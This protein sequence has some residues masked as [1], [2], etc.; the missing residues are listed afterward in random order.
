MRECDEVHKIVR[1]ITRTNVGGPSVQ[2]ATLMRGLDSTKY[3]QTLLRGACS[4][5]EA[6]YFDQ[7][8]KGIPTTTIRGLRREISVFGDLRAFVSIVREMR[9]IRPTLVHTHTS[10]A[11]LLGRLAAL[12][13]RTPIIVHT[14]HG[15][16]FD[17]Y[18][19]KIVTKA[20]I[21]VERT[22]GKR[23]T[24]IVAVGTQTLNELVEFRILS[25]FHSASVITP[26]VNPPAQADGRNFKKTLGINTQIVVTFVGRLTQIKRPDR[27]IELARRSCHLSEVTFL[28]VGDG[29]LRTSIE[30]T[31]P[32]NVKF[33]GWRNDLEVIYGATDIIVLTSDNEGTPV[34][35][36]EAAMYG[37]PAVST[38]VGSVRDIVD[39]G[40]TGFV[41]RKDEDDDLIRRTHELI[42]NSTLRAE[43]GSQARTRACKQFT[44]E[45]FLENYDSLYDELF[46]SAGLRD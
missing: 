31:S 45:R 4:R 22:L 14:F 23:T 15:H 9:R 6:D 10:K 42:G 3:S 46:K 25:D 5:G 17:G 27:F 13:L 11:G 44:V 30:K 35:L 21:A 7:A 40:R 2:V 39:S 36:I 19:P 16:V 34:A 43:F 18:F 24:H 20:I 33:L 28:V 32:P 26:G 37:I 1:V 38:E 29:E 12:T 41:V 8:G